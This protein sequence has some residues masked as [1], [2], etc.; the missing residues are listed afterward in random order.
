MQYYNEYEI[1]IVVYVRNFFVVKLA[2]VTLPV[3][4]INES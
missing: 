4:L 2:N 3:M 1:I